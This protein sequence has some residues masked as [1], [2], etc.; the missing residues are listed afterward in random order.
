MGAPNS[1]ASTGCLHTRTFNR[2]AKNRGKHAK[3][4]ISNLGRRRTTAKASPLWPLG[5]KVRDLIR[6][7]TH[8]TK[9]GEHRGSCIGDTVGCG[10]AVSD[11]NCLE[12]HPPG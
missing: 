2:F 3:T 7:Q 5:G 1:G 12:F 4:P 10:E 8:I 11:C 6:R 9:L